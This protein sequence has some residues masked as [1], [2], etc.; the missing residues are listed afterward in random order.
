MPRKLQRFV[1]DGIVSYRDIGADRSDGNFTIVKN[2][3]VWLNAQ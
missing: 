3:P 1:K 2:R